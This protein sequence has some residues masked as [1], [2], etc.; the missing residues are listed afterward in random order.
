MILKIPKVLIKS[1]IITGGI[2]RKRENGGTMRQK[3]QLGSPAVTFRNC[4]V[5]TEQLLSERGHQL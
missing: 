5:L 3:A 4:P 2:N 1:K